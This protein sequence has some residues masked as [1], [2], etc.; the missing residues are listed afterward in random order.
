MVYEWAPRLSPSRV[1]EFIKDIYL[2]QYAPGAGENLRPEEKIVVMLWGPPG[3][4]KTDSVKAASIEL[5]G[6]LGRRYIDC[7]SVTGELFRS[8]LAEPEKYFVFC[9]IKLERYEYSDLVGLP[10]F[11]SLGDIHFTDWYPPK[12]V[13]VLGLKGVAGILFL[14]ELTNAAPDAV[15]CAMEAVYEKKLGDIV[16]SPHVMIVAA[17]NPPEYSSAARS[18]PEPLMT[19][20]A[21]IW[22]DIGVDEWI[23]WARRNGV[24]DTVIEYLRRNPEKINVPWLNAVPRTWAILGKAVRNN[25]LA[26][27]RRELALA[28]TGINPFIAE[29]KTG[30]SDIV[31]VT[32]R[33]ASMYRRARTLKAK[34]ELLEK[35]IGMTDAPVEAEY[36]IAIISKIASA[37]KDDMMLEDTLYIYYTYNCVKSNNCE[38][39]LRFADTVIE[40][41][42]RNYGD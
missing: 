35:L 17:G 24:D 22:V 7:N 30:I 10:S 6:L 20:L 16:F 8:I 37:L 31:E 41:N 4:G 33:L 1:T 28:L 34:L 12:W 19:R 36:K 21:H 11:R 29:E 27:W 39:L 25:R 26:Q 14:D 2:A 18:L 5:A 38:H 42:V 13:A 32:A 9:D 15:K 3:V 40:I 23:E